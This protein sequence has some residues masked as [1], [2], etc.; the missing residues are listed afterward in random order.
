MHKNTI[1]LLAALIAAAA[2]IYTAILA[3]LGKYSAELRLAHRKTIEPHI[4]ELAKAI[5]ETLA[6]SNILIKAR[7]AESQV[8]WR[9]RADFAKEK[10]K[11]LRVMLKYSLWGITNGLNTLTR[12]PDWIEHARAFPENAEAIFRRGKK[13]GDTLDN[14]IRHSYTKGVPPSWIDRFRILRLERHLRRE[15]A[16]FK[17]QHKI[18]EK[19]T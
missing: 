13:L 10:L 1:T 15:Y 5:H 2:S 7:S 12:L 17:G 16:R 3:F 18:Q 8:N 4:C 19:D 9:E 14:V 11:D 6:T